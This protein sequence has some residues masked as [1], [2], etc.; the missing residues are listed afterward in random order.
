MTDTVVVTASVGAFPGLVAALRK[1]PVMVE[2]RPLMNFAPPLDWAPFDAALNRIAEYRAVVFTSP[3]AAEPFA[4]RLKE[5]RAHWAAEPDLPAPWASGPQ[6]ATALHGALGP[7]RLPLRRGRGQLGAAKALARA[8][9]EEKVCGPVLFPCGEAH[10]DELPAELRQSGI[11]V[12]EIVCYRSVLAGESEAR[13][14]ASRGSVL[15]VA[16]PRVASLLARACP[17]GTRPELLAVGP[18]TAESARAAGWSPSA[19]ASEPTARALA[20]AVR[21]LLANR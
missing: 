4:A 11:A 16:S 1:I 6:T 18:T 2:E 14:A 9:L 15:V 19:V 13:V 3:R 7:V 5:R 21:S 8:M 10:R 12:D 20:S 17:R